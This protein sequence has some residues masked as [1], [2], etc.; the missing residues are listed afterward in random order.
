MEDFKKQFV[1]QKFIGMHEKILDI[2]IEKKTD[3]TA[4]VIK[5][6]IIH[7]YLIYDIEHQWQNPAWGGVSDE[8][9]NYIEES[10]L[11]AVLFDLN[12]KTI[13]KING[14]NPNY[15]FNN[16]KYCDETVVYIGRMEDAWGHFMHETLARVWYLVDNPNSNY[17]IAYI[18]CGVDS[19]L[20][21]ITFLGFPKEKFIRINE[22]TKFKEV[23][24]PEECVRNND[25]YHRK[26]K[27]IIDKMIKDIPPSSQKKIYLSRALMP[28]QCK[29]L[30]ENEIEN[31][32]RQN[33]YT[34]ISP[35]TLSPQGKIALMKG[36]ETIVT[37]QG[38]GPYNVLFSNE[39]SKLVILNTSSIYSVV[40]PHYVKK[41]DLYH[42]DIYEEP[43]PVHSGVGPALL[44]LTPYL[45]AFFDHFK[46]KYNK[47]DF[48]KR[49]PI[50]LIEFYKAWMGLYSH[51]TFVLLLKDY[52][53]DIDV[54]Q[55]KAEILKAFA[56]YNAQ[57]NSL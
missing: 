30:G 57:L 8:N 13:Q 56:N 2:D 11:K 12:N 15:D 42:V 53:P 5:N 34:V 49:Y 10:S 39:G 17:K 38:S 33:G 44:T 48:L 40:F 19:L 7:P 55:T 1:C 23:I 29:C 28:M 41:I 3:L 4:K 25:V 37:A 51:K 31:V 16:I 43:L 46:L 21:Y 20:E 18:A 47:D 26:Y 22:P 6:G 52:Y 27:T 50:N 45:E 54:E 14:F 32:F 24:I 36:A 35:E 9:L